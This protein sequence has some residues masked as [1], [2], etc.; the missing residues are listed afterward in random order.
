ME[1]YPLNFAPMKMVVTMHDYAF[2][3]KRA[4]LFDPLSW[5][6]PRYTPKPQNVQIFF[7]TSIEGLRSATDKQIVDM[8][9]N[10]LKK[11][12]EYKLQIENSNDY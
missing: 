7:E 3:I 8:V 12:D 10:H 9:R 6:F 4:R 2:K 5:I 11:L 1:N